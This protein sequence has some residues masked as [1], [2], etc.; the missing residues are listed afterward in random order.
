VK[1]D[2]DPRKRTCCSQPSHAGVVLLLANGA[3]AMPIAAS[4]RSHWR[5][6]SRTRGH[7]HFKTPTRRFLG[8]VSGFR[9][10]NPP[11]QRWINRDPQGESGGNNL[12]SFV[13]NAPVS[14]VDPYGLVFIKRPIPPGA[15]VSPCPKCKFSCWR[16]LHDFWPYQQDACD[17]SDRYHGLVILV[18]PVGLTL[19]LNDGEEIYLRPGSMVTACEEVYQP[20]AKWPTVPRG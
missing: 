5:S 17:R 14:Y 10:Y 7:P 20:P 3:N 6:R 16:L 15:K 18:G 19:V 2:T 12:Y 4:G 13:Q 9:Y 8:T 11:L 1:K